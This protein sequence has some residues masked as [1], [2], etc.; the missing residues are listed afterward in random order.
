MGAP[1]EGIKVLDL[2]QW[3]AVPGTGM[4]LADQG[5]EVIKV[6]P[7][8][9]DEA[10]RLFTTPFLGN[11]SKSFMVV[12]RNKRGMVVDITKEPGRKI[13]YQLVER[14]DVLLENFRPGVAERLGFG[15]DRLSRL[16]P[17]LIYA[18]V[19]AYGRKGPYAQKPGYDMVLQALSGVMGYR[20]MPDGSPIS[21][22]TWIA[23][24]STPMLLAYG[25][26]LALYL[27]E[28]TGR[29]Q[30]VETS[31]LYLAIAMQSVELVK[32]EEDPAPRPSSFVAT[33]AAYRCQD[34]LYLV[35]VVLTEKE[36]ARLC[37][38]LGLE[39][40][41]NHS[42]Y[43]SHPKRAERSE[44]LAPLLGGIFATRPREEWLR[45][46]QEAEVPS[47]PVL[48]REEVFSEPQV[49]ENEMIIEVEHPVAKK[50]KMMGIPV[51][52]SENPPAMKR[53]APTLGQ[54]T[55]EV[56]RELGYSQRE[57]DKL[58]EEGAILTRSP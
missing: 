15:Y 29:G 18:S 32:V 47:A 37:R 42:L 21:A 36:W 52:L 7:P 50:T 19:T 40:L 14:S 27:R 31:L 5:A 39:H 53:P 8:G 16:N 20:H 44:E 41:S 13:I 35:I 46:L 12:N 45:A 55:Q 28:R 58:R 6:E 17:R 30:R 1:L 9:G 26:M 38:V 48:D 4:Y 54:H 22:G 33:Y 25:I 57:M 51:W 23:D 11:E 34:G 3:W 56:L 2:S 43:N 49:L 10:R 24:C